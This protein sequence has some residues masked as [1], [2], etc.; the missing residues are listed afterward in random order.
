MATGEL[1]TLTASVDAATTA[2]NGFRAEIQKQNVFALR[3]RALIR[4][5]WVAFIVIGLLAVGLGFVAINARHTAQVANRNT[6]NAVDACKTANKARQ[7]SSDLWNYILTLP[8]TRVLTPAEQA[9]INVQTA[10]LRARIATTYAQQDCSKLAP[11][12]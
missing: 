4:R 1:E 12:K 10:G 8:P 2:I 7:T 3:S 11:P 9:A 5:L 6:V